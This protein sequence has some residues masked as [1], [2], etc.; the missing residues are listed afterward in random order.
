VRDGDDL[1]GLRRLAAGQR[2]EQVSGTLGRRAVL[3]LIALAL[4]APAGAAASSTWEHWTGRWFTCWIPTRSW[5][6]AEGQ[7]N[8]NIS[9]PTGTDVVTYQYATNNPTPVT[10]AWVAD[11]VFR[12]QNEDLHPLSGVRIIRRGA[13]TN[14]NGGQR[15]VFEWTG[16]RR[17]RSGGTEAVHGILITAAYANPATGAYAFEAYAKAAPAATWRTRAALLESIRG[18][19]AFYGHR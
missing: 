8:L 3:A 2:D 12:N 11:L 10:P 9:S 7:N 5:R 15:Q 4:S 17:Y 18:H 19:I 14:V 6:V 1:S 13:L 16:T